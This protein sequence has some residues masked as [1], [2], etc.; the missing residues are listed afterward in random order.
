MNQITKE[1]IYNYQEYHQYTPC[2]SCPVTS[3]FFMRKVRTPNM[4]MDKLLGV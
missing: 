1:R 4:M 3:D 2:D